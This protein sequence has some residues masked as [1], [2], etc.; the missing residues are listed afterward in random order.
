MKTKKSCTSSAGTEWR[1]YDNGCA[2]AGRGNL[3][4][5][6]SD[7]LTDPGSEVEVCWPHSKGD[8]RD[9]TDADAG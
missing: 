8:D 3:G 5:I 7:C 6:R 1:G 2:A 9:Q 4:Y